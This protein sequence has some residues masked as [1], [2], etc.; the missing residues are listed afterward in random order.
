ML[1]RTGQE[2]AALRRQLDRLKPDDFNGKYRING[3]I[4]LA[5]FFV[6]A[7]DLVRGKDD[8]QDRWYRRGV[9]LVEAPKYTESVD[10]ALL[11]LAHADMSPVTCLE[12]IRSGRDSVLFFTNRGFG[13]NR[14]LAL[15]I[16]S[17]ALTELQRQAENR[18]AGL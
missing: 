4:H 11:V 13:P 9:P 1:T 6:P 10:A 3:N 15:A 16:L 5:F 2:I 14:A 8:Q 17:R 18:E 12:L 7:A